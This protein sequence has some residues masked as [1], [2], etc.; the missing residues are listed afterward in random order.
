M[1]LLDKLRSNKNYRLVKEIDIHNIPNATEGYRIVY[2]RFLFE[3][4]RI[5]SIDKYPSALSLKT[6]IM[7]RKIDNL[8]KFLGGDEWS[9][10]GDPIYYDRCGYLLT[11]SI[12]Q[13]KIDH[14]IKLYSDRPD[15]LLST[16][17]DIERCLSSFEKSNYELRLDICKD[18]IHTFRHYIDSGVYLIVKLRRWYETYD[19]SLDI[20]LEQNPTDIYS[21]GTSLENSFIVKKPIDIVDT[22]STFLLDQYEDYHVS[23]KRKVI[24]L[25]NNILSYGERLK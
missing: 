19:I 6:Y 5:R 3:F 8:D 17:V 20:S 4:I 13:Q 7:M 15:K 1:P 25:I 18:P 10:S 23:V 12:V 9:L 24:N 14:L 2:D 16:I 22:L 11:S 21:I